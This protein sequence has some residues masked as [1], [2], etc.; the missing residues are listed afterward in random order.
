MLC[1]LPTLFPATS[2]PLA[3]QSIPYSTSAQPASAAL[4]CGFSKGSYRE[5][6]AEGG[7]GG[8]Y[9]SPNC[10]S[11]QFRENVQDVL[12]TLPNPDDYFLLRWLRGEGRGA[13]GGWAEAGSEYQSGTLRNLRIWGW[14][15]FRVKMYLAITKLSLPIGQIEI[16]RLREVR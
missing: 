11:L 8:T 4:S 7:Q 16:L 3:R 15:A 9:H 1:S 10:L 6:W 14:S 12:P 5:S 13:V 2:H